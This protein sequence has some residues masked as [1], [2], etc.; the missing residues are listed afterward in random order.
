M[1]VVEVLVP[2]FVVLLG[3]DAAAILLLL[4][5]LLLPKAAAVLLLPH[6][7]YLL[8]C[9]SMCR[10]VCTTTTSICWAASFFS[11]GFRDLLAEESVFVCVCVCV[12][13]HTS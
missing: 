3:V 12:R 9:P 10:N 4:L 8:Y 13:A 2:L 6:S 11:P 1:V 7:Y 5:L